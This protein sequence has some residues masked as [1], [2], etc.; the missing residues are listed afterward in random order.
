VIL[1]GT[2]YD[3]TA[4]LFAVKRHDGI[5]IVQDPEEATFPGMPES[6]IGNV[7]VDY[8]LPV[9]EIAE[10]LARLAR[11]DES[12]LEEAEGDRAMSSGRDEFEQMPDIVARDQ[13]EQVN[14]ERHGQASL[15]TCPDCGGTLWQV[16]EGNVLQFR[17][18]VGH[19]YTAE[20]IIQ[21]Q[22]EALER[23]LWFAVRT[24]VDKSLL[25]RQLAARAHQRGELERSKRLTEESD[26]AHIHSETIRR[27]LM[28]NG[29]SGLD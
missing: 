1:S 7:E 28:G 26:Q 20:G 23:S 27:M 9:A 3:G 24:L 5:A 17:C 2:L 21:E 13:D 11:G 29:A 16:N 18:H 6:A 8:I 15:F 4:G 22:S 25:L 19:V 10:M 14:G 12:G